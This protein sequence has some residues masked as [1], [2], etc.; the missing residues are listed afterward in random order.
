MEL[1]QKHA[2]KV[3]ARVINL[4]YS[5]LQSQSHQP[6]PSNPGASMVQFSQ[7]DLHLS[8]HVP[9]ARSSSVLWLL[10]CRLLGN[11]GQSTS[12][13]WHYWQQ[14]KCWH[15]SILAQPRSHLALAVVGVS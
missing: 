13:S 3:Q 7:A 10:H 5:H 8:K 4:T 6:Q 2:Q 15:S 9:D 14:R 12:I 11:T 1:S